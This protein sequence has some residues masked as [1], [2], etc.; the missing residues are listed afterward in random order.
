MAG[1]RGTRLALAAAEP[2]PAPRRLKLVKVPGNSCFAPQDVA[3]ELLR[4]EGVIDVQYTTVAPGGSAKAMA[5]GEADIALPFA[6]PLMIR[7][8]AGAPIVMLAGGHIGCFELFGP[9]RIGSI[10]DLRG[11]TVAVPTLGSPAHVCVA[12]IAAYVG[13]EPRQDINWVTYPAAESMQL[14]GEGKLDAFLGFPPQPQELRAR[15]IGHVVVNSAI[16][17]PW[18]QYFCCMMAGNREFVQKHPVAAKRAL[19]AILK[20]AN[21]CAREPDRVTRFLVDKGYTTDHTDMFQ[22][23]LEMPYG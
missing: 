10:R 15:K 7:V 2:P 19:R 11:K 9:D 6:G 16:D 12:S 22:A 23:M 1:L 13:L 4:T 8:D 21:V 20:A 18:S 14:L 3:E 17:R 5:S